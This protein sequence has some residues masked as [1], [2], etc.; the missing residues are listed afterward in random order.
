MPHTEMDNTFVNISSEALA[1]CSDESSPG[2]FFPFPRP[3][4]APRRLHVTPFPKDP[5]PLKRQRGAASEKLLSNSRPE[6]EREN[7]TRHTCTPS[8]VLK[9][10]SFAP[11]TGQGNSGTENRWATSQPAG[12]LAFDYHHFKSGCLANH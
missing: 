10:N 8:S 5:S 4:A 6:C 3:T 7:P 2:G 11:G 1:G 9:D 12:S